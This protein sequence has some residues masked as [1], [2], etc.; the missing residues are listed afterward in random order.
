MKNFFKPTKV[1]WRAFALL[2]LLCAPLFWAV[3]ADAYVLPFFDLSP[4]MVERIAWIY[5]L[6][7]F[8]V[9]FVADGYLFV[10]IAVVLLYVLASIISFFLY[11][12]QRKSNLR[13]GEDAS[14]IV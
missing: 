4:D 12:N 8:P 11:R 14:K 3:I 1:T 5:I 6:I 9:L 2:F 10:V 13:T 7:A